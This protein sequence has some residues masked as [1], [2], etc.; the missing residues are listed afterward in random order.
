MPQARAYQSSGAVRVAR[1]EVAS[2]GGDVQAAEPVACRCA[3]GF[4]LAPAAIGLDG[5]VLRLHSR[6]AGVGGPRVGL[7]L[8]VGRHDGPRRER[9]H[10]RGNQAG[11]RRAATGPP[12][13]ALEVAHRPGADRLAGEAAPEVLGQRGGRVIAFARLLL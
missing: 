3:G 13:Q 9:Q 2:A 4:G 12:G 1:V 7:N 5:A 6:G 10:G 8:E 11:Q